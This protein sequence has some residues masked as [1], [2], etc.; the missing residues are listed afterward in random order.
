[1]VIP[2]LL[3]LVL[4]LFTYNQLKVDLFPTLNFPVLNIIT[5]SPTQSSLE[6][7]RQVTTPIESVIGGVLGVT[8][9]RSTSATGISMV[10][11]EFHWG[12]EMIRAKQL[13]TE[14]L[15]GIRS[16]LPPG[17]EPSIENL[18]NALSMLQGYSLRGGSNPVQLRDL[19]W[20]AISMS[21]PVGDS[22]GA[23]DQVE[24]TL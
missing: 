2:L 5:E 14:A 21:I 11:A 1:M 6:V 20:L 23:I 3:L 10:S 17:L 24:A 16:Q 9:V 7:E 13:V 8:R 15:S 4:G 22:P 19:A 12:T 18:S